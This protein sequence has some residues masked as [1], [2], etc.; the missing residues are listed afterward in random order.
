MAEKLLTET[1]KMYKYFSSKK[2]KGRK[3]HIKINIFFTPHSE[4]E[5]ILFYMYNVW[6][7]QRSMSKQST[8]TYIKK[9]CV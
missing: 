9:K 4:P 6:Y 3:V 1:T 7:Y 5:S 2:L 8:N